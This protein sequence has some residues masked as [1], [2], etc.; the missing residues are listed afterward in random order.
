MS[1]I[2]FIEGGGSTRK[3]QRAARLAF[4]ELFRN[5]GLAGSMPKV[6]ACGSRE[7]AYEDFC[8]ALADDSS[9]PILLVDSEGAVRTTDAWSH[10]TQEDDWER[11]QSAGADSAH[12]MVQ[13]MEA[14]FLADRSALAA[15]FGQGFRASALPQ[16]AQIEDIS[17]ADVLRGIGEASRR[18]NKP[19]AKGRDSFAILQRLNIDK[20]MDACPHAKRLI[21]T[22]RRK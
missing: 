10:L 20:L 11:P 13:V 3:Q 1:K 17:K 15:Y 21:E 19:Y 12:L 7:Q 22:L 14:W 16:R 4:T 2:V 18:T 6:S 5:A 9:D 8:D